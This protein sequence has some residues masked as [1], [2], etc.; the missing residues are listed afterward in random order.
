MQEAA[1]RVSRR[2]GGA[3]EGLARRRRFPPPPT[4]P[5]QA[6]PREPALHKWRAHCAAGAAPLLARQSYPLSNAN[7]F[8]GYN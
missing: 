2:A 5:C 6:W 3:P 7:V 4:R 8:F 1:R